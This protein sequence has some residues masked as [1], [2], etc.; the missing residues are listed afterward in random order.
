LKPIYAVG[1]TNYFFASLK[2]ITAQ[3]L[4]A[5]RSKHLSFYRFATQLRPIMSSAGVIALFLPQILSSEALSRYE[6]ARLK[7]K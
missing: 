2:P 5:G 7:V 3:H 4:K 6:T 1:L